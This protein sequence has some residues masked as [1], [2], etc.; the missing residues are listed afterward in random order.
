MLFRWPADSPCS[1]GTASADVVVLL[2]GAVT[3]AHI[4]NAMQSAE[5]ISFVH[6]FSLYFGYLWLKIS[7][8]TANPMPTAV[9]N[10]GMTNK[11][12]ILI[13]QRRISGSFRSADDS[14][15]TTA[16]SVRLFL[17]FLKNIRFHL[18]YYS[19]CT[20][21]R[22]SGRIRLSVNRREQTCRE[23]IEETVQQAQECIAAQGQHK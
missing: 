7:R 19:F 1:V 15:D 8:A 16:G 21:Y 23:I 17:F 9:P 14:A 3:T 4:T 6:S 22:S 10:G 13:G 11:N 2:S 20:G 5:I 12:M 18:L